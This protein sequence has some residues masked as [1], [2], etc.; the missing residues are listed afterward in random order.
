M[1][2]GKSWAWLA[3]ALAVG[4]STGCCR[5]CERWCPPHQ[6]AAAP[7]GYQQ[8]CVPC[9]VPC[10]PQGASGYQPAPAPMAPAPQGWQRTYSQ[11]VGY[12]QPAPAAMN[13]CQ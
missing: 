8:A 9:C 1:M 12:G 5:I 10:C 4:T 11:P 7:V 2:Y 13:C 6:S 3:I